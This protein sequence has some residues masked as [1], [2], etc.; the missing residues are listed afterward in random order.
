M[1]IDSFPLRHISVRVP[2]HDNGWNGT[3]C[4][5]PAQNTACIKLKNISDSKDDLR[6]ENLRGQSIESM[7]WRE[8]PPCVKERA[9]FMAPFA[10]DRFH[11]H[12]YSKTSPET[13]AHFGPTPMHYPAFSA[14]ALPFR[15]L[16]RSELEETL[17]KQHPLEGVDLSREPKLPFNTNWIQD[18]QNHESALGTFWSY[19]R[20]RESLVFFYAKQVPFVEDDTR[21]VLIGAGVVEE[22]GD[23]CE[24]SYEGSPEGKIRSLMWERMVKHSIRTDGLNGFLLPYQELMA[25][26]EANPNLDLSEHAVFAPNE[27]FEEFSFGTEHVSNDSAV[28]GLAALRAGLLKA[29]S[30]L[31]EFDP[32]R[33]EKWIDE[34]SGRLWKKRGA[35]PGL[36]AMLSAFGLHLG[37][38]ISHAVV[39]KAGDDGDPWPVLDQMF[40]KPTNILSPELASNV[41]ATMCKTWQRLSSERRAFLQLISRINLTDEQARILY[42][43]RSREENG[44]NISDLQILENPYLIYETTRLTLSPVAVS[45]VDRGVFPTPSIREK[46]PVPP[47]SR[48]TTATDARRLR[49]LI[50]AELER[51]ALAGDTL[52]P[53]DAIQ[54]ALRAGTE[55]EQGALVTEDLLAV[56]E[57]ENFGDEIISVKMADGGIAYQLGRFKRVGLKIRQTIDKRT[58]DKAGPL[59]VVADWRKRLDEHLKPIP[60]D[61]DRATEENARI[62]KAAALKQLASSMFSVLVGPAGTGKTTLLSVLCGHPDIS[63]GKILLLA[64]TGKAR[65]RMES[66]A[67]KAGTQNFHA[68]T[69][70]QFLWKSRRYDGRTGRYCLQPNQIA[71]SGWRTVIVDESSMLTEEMLAAL[72]EGLSGVHRFVLVGDTAQL[73]PIG[74]GRPFVDIVRRLQPEDIESRFPRVAP[75]YVELTVPRRQ[76]AGNRDDLQL[77]TWFATRVGGPGDDEIFEILTG[78]RA[79]PNLRL[80]EWNTAGELEALLPKVL[81]EELGIPQGSDE[82]VAFA[83]SLGGSEYKGIVYFHAGKL[84][85][86]DNQVHGADRWQI[87]T[88]VRQKP[89][90][91]EQIN[92]LLH[93]RF[94]GHT[95]AHARQHPFKRKIPKPMGTQQIVYGDKVINN[96]NQRPSEKRIYDPKNIGAKYLANGEIGLVT[97]HLRSQTRNW[98][99]KDLEIEFSTQPGVTYTF[100]GSD[101]AEEAEVKLELAYALTV[102]KAQ[103]SEFGLVFLVLPRGTRLLNREMLY[104]SLTRQRQKIVILHQGP[105]ADLQKLSHWDF[106]SAAQRLTNLFVA[107]KPRQIGAQG[108]RFLEERLIH[109]TLHGELVRSK[110]ELIIADNLHREGVRYSYERPL[111]LDGFL[112]F[113]DFTID[114]E[115]TNI[116]YYWEHCGMLGDANYRER[117]EAKQRWY[118][119]RQILPYQEGGGKKGTLIVTEDTLQGG[120]SS[121]E[122]L[123]LIHTVILGQP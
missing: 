98:V 31:P 70:A 10:F 106:S 38:F 96:R 6:E 97:G 54:K 1:K 57:E 20:K 105:A 120:I 30:V 89:W 51:V 74:A 26:G 69:L 108:G 81:A 76:G 109:L 103:G 24:Y 112:K 43:N 40:K 32:R 85:P 84:G 78:R 42:E 44:V 122:I 91:V 2:W 94:R 11:V 33:A 88:P 22:L 117:W 50:V 80:V 90:G 93:Q 7:D 45:L 87:L 116:T 15:W 37:H 113:P 73:P 100:Y 16:M 9:T 17:M 4:C 110:S 111:A 28:A 34:Q 79:S 99:P 48:V 67:R 13:H 66:I 71:E 92:R 102:H 115:D 123:R 58:S 118:R 119:D 101:F 12:P 14:A 104:T 75:G 46:F 121:P 82:A 114:D 107:P 23:L 49:A 59:A 60:N 8:F 21:R 5:R 52:C 77:A 27:R 62:E 95:L 63:E 64:P 68:A 86:S 36:G 72:F 19:V 25:A 18:K 65:V 35:F 55:E 39:T 53:R 56:A 3:V 41:D 29:A 61:A 47:P 83:Q